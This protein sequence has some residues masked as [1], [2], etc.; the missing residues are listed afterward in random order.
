MITTTLYTLHPPHYSI[1]ETTH[2]ISFI[3][4]FS[5]QKKQMKHIIK[6]AVLALVFAGALLVIELVS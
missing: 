6:G 5:L 1:D 2:L 4:C 3:A